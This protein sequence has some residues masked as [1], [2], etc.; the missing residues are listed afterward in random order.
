MHVFRGKS[1]FKLGTTIRAQAKKHNEEEMESD[2][3]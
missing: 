1:W 3:P 2:L